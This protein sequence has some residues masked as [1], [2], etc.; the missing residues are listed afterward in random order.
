MIGHNPTTM[1]KR[2]RNSGSFNFSEVLLDFFLSTPFF[3]YLLFTA[4]MCSSDLVIVFYL[5]ICHGIFYCVTMDEYRYKFIKR[6]LAP[7]GLHCGRCFAFSEGHICN[8]SKQLKNS[9]G[10]FDVYAERF[11]KLLDEPV[12][13][14]YPDFKKFLSLLSSGSCN[15]C[16]EEQCK[17]YKSCNVRRCSESRYVD[18]C[19]QCGEFPCGHTGFDK[20][21]Y[22]RHIKIN[23]RMK[24]IGI[25][26]Y[27]EEV[28]NLSR[29]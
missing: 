6:R 27:Y 3:I 20:H 23:R 4:F 29:Y 17:I 26:N 15:G 22:Q 25:E 1:K 13:L 12:F 10:N 5:Y 28:K 2:W 9:L 16:R 11:V 18:F 19:F 24:E 7:C 21:L 8:Y 14:K